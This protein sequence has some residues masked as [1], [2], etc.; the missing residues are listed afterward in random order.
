M[1]G[2]L[3]PPFDWLNGNIPPEWLPTNG[4]PSQK[5]V[6]YATHV[7]PDGKGGY[8]GLTFPYG[9]PGVS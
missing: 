6:G 4:P 9:I 3:P 8:V 7:I 5:D 1:R 2:E